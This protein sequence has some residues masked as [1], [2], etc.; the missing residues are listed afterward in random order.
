MMQ[1][2]FNINIYIVS[3]GNISK[4]FE[5]FTFLLL[6]T[7]LLEINTLANKSYNQQVIPLGKRVERS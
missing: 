2:Y 5:N 6:F 4:N 3:R 7:F 1:S